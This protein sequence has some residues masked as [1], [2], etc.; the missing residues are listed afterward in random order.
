MD[1]LRKANPNVCFL[2]ITNNDCWLRVGR[3]RRILNRNTQ[4]V[5]QAM[6]ELARE[7]DGA[8]W[9]QFRIM[10]G[11][12]SSNRWVNARLMNRDHIHFLRP[13]YELL[14]DLLYNALTIE[15]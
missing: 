12:G 4:K 9:N 5:E 15:H 7:C 1:E 13:G 2:F 14:A 10:G 3:Q 6:M 8:V 11:Y